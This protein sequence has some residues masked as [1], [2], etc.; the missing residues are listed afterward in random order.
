MTLCLKDSPAD[1][2]TIDKSKGE[3]SS[4]TFLDMQERYTDVDTASYV[5]GGKHSNVSRLT[6][7]DTRHS[8]ISGRTVSDD[9]YSNIS[10][11]TVSDDK[12]SNISGRTVTEV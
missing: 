6:V 5:S 4:H 10:G 9:K 1:I 11:R 12:Y 7:S 3:E 2:S 8:N